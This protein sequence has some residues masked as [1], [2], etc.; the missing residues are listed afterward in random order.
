MAMLYL[1]I[2]GTEDVA[3]L[4]RKDVICFQ[5]EEFTEEITT[6]NVALLLDED[7]GISGMYIYRERY[8]KPILLYFS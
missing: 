5:G 1:G 2:H 3:Q 4:A 8:S 6:T 7:P